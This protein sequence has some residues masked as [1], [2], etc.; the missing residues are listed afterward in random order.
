MKSLEELSLFAY[1]FLED[2]E[3]ASVRRHLETCPSCSEKIRRLNSERN[4]FERAAAREGHPDVPPGLFQARARR[5]R[6]S[7]PLAGLAASVLLGVLVWLLAFPTRSK[8]GPDAEI[9]GQTLDNDLDRLVAELKSPSMLKRELATLAL[10][11]YG[12]LAVEKLEKAKADPALLDACRG[13]SAQDREVQKQ[14]QAAR[15]ALDMENVPLVD[16]LDRVREASQLNL[17]ISGIADPNERCSFKVSEVPVETALRLLLEPRGYTFLVKDGVV[18]VTTREYAKTLKPVPAPSRVPVRFPVETGAI[19]RAII[20]LG[21]EATEERDRSSARLLRHGFAAESALWA[22]L[23]STSAE[24]RARAGDLLRQF[25]VPRERK[26]ATDVERALEERILSMDFENTRIA[27]ILKYMGDSL[28]LPMILGSTLDPDTKVTFKTRGLSAKNN[29]KLLLAQRAL[30]YLIKDGSLFITIPN[31]SLV[32]SSRLP[33][34]AA[35]EEA[36]K[37]RV[38]LEKTIQGE[39]AEVS[40]EAQIEEISA[41]IQA[42][43]ALEGPAMERCRRAAARLAEKAHLWLIDQPSGAELQSLTEAQRTILSKP[44]Q[45]AEG[46]S[47]GALFRRLGLKVLY[48][49][50]FDRSLRV[51]GRAV[52][53]SSLL[54]FLAR[55]EGVDFYLEGET[56]IL[57]TSA[58]VRAAVE[59]EK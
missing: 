9:L 8:G 10:K 55:P 35:P 26:P 3:A 11:G 54:K 47:L 45:P 34:W 19:E 44:C 29:L 17:H 4:V 27:D 23:D 22:A 15:V 59:K 30:D 7:L 46:E 13:T 52:S 12:S 5:L 36:A 32:R 41:L 37:L 16:I 40:E 33:L 49:V 39:S 24:V 58:N 25:Y 18:M 2:E 20:G 50:P 43:E 57:D 53:V 31:T 56:I 48:R 1:G 6:M 42:S 21:A 38:I 51:F 28:G 14:L